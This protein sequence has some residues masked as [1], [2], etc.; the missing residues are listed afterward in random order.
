MPCSSQNAASRCSSRS[1]PA[2]TPTSPACAASD[3][4]WFPAML[5]VPTIAARA[6]G[7]RPPPAVR[8]PAA[9]H[10]S[11]RES[12]CPQ[13]RSRRLVL[14]KPPRPSARTEPFRVA[15]PPH[16]AMPP[17]LWHTWGKRFPIG[18]ERDPLSELK[19]T[20]ALGSHVDV[21]WGDVT[22]FRYVH[23][24]DVP[25]LE[26]PKPYLHPVRTLAGDLVTAYRPHY[27]VWHKGI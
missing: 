5:P 11:R 25:Q 20:H 7:T 22:L 23:H 19:I 10:R 4:A 24:P 13:N 9:P 14:V 15:R 17:R 6:V 3:R 27:H 2:T 18:R 8:F 21:A 26:S 16:A 1:T 12:A